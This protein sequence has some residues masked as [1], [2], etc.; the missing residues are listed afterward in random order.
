MVKVKYHDSGNGDAFSP[1]RVNIIIHM[2]HTFIFHGPSNF[3]LTKKI[4]TIQY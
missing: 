1:N 2:G 3:Q 4:G